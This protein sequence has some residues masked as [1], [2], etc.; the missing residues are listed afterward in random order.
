[1]GRESEIIDT[2]FERADFRG[3]SCCSP[4]MRSTSFINCKLDG[5]V[6]ES[7]L[8]S[9]V[10][11]SGKYNELTIRAKPGDP[12]RN[13]LDL[14]L[15]KAKVTWVDCDGGVDLTFASLPLDASCIVIRERLRAVDV[16]VR[17]LREDAGEL[18]GEVARFLDGIFSERS[19]SPLEPSQTTFLISYGMIA[20]FVETDD[21]GVVTPLYM[22]VRAIAEEAGFLASV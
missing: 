2:I 19:M 13:R 11:M 10:Q 14:D 16:L 22:K 7:A 1:M 8:F 17:R 12:A 20:K 18:G 6:F 3:A 15:S 5:F 9:A 4:V 21:E